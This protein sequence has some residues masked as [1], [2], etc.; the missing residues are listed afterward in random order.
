[1]TKQFGTAL[2]ALSVLALVG[3]APPK[4]PPEEAPPAAPAAA[5]APV[6][7]IPPAPVESYTCER[8]TKLSVKL[9]G[10]TA[11]V[12]VDGAEP[13]SLPVL[14]N[15]GTTYTNGRLTLMIVQGKVSFAK[16]R[17]AAEACAPG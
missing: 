2:A 5:D 7:S 11:E 16:G 10:A 4:A 17:M 12:G 8:G 13:V 1:M 15:E 3:C 9:L 14:G 6:A